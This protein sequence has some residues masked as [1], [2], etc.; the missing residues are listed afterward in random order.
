MSRPRNIDPRTLGKIEY[1]ASRLW[2]ELEAAVREHEEPEDCITTYGCGLCA[3]YV[4]VDS[5][6]VWILRRLR[7]SQDDQLARTP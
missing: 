2:A 5:A 1:I 7:Q 3:A 6:L 4:L